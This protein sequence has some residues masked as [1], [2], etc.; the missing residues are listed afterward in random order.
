MIALAFDFKSTA[1]LLAVKPTCALADDLGVEVQ[2]LPFPTE[3]RGA[4]PQARPDETVGERHARVRAAY[5]ARDVARYARWQGVEVNRDAAG[6]DSML[7]RAGCLWASRH[8]VARQYVER[9]MTDFWAGRLDIEN[10]GA[11]ASVLDEVG[12]PGFAATDLTAELAS[13]EADLRDR[14]VFS[15]PTYLVDG[16]VFQGREHLPMIRWLLSGSEGP[17]PL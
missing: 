6:V 17:G 15:V 13:T 16:Q 10:D 2:W 1:A 9:T 3:V 7:A 12:A 5:V 11:L 4:P 8:G 14:G